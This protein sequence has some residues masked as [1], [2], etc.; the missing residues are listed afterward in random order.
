[1]LPYPAP[2]IAR[3]FVNMGQSWPTPF[4]RS[5]ATPFA[6]EEC[7]ISDFDDVLRASYRDQGSWAVCLFRQ[8]QGTTRRVRFPPYL[9]IDPGL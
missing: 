5:T 3:L 9:V 1:M 8:A 4:T 7:H 2:L 6:R